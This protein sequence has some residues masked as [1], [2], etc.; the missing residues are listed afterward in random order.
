M[1]GKVNVAPFSREYNV[2]Y[3]VAIS[4]LERDP[5]QEIAIS[6]EPLPFYFDNGEETTPSINIL[7]WNETLV[8]IKI[9]NIIG[10]N[11]FSLNY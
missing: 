7:M 6:V 2:F 9:L 1:V 5:M 4:L 11:I 8:S 10:F 3:Q